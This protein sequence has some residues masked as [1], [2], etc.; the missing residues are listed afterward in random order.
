ML[1][2]ATSSDDFVFFDPPYYPISRTSYFTAYSRNSFG[3]KEQENLRDTCEKL[4]SRGVKLW[5]VILIVNLFENF[6]K[7]SILI[8]HNIKASR[9]INS[10]AK[11]AGNN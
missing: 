5:Y 1:N 11:K 6:I 10:N 9:S 2:H 7:I 4:A 3:E 8:L